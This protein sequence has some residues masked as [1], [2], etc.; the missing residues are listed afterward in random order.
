MPTRRLPS[1]R[2]STQPTSAEP[3]AWLDSAIVVVRGQR[4]I[5]S[6]DL[7]AVYG[8]APKAFNQAIRRN[9]ERFPPDFA[10]RLTLDEAR[11]AVRSRSQSV[12]LNEQP[13]AA[14]KILRSQSV[15]L[16]A[17][18]PRRAEISRSQS[19][20]LSWGA[21]IKYAPLAFTEHG[22]VMAAS[23]LNSPKAVEMSVFV[24]RAF[25]RLRSLVAGQKE[26]AAQLTLLE[27]RVSGHDQGLKAIIS[28]LRRLQEPPPDP[29][30]PA[31]WG[32]LKVG[33]GI[34]CRVALRAL[35]G[36]S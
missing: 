28:A 17:A 32:L 35:V 34:S 9:A 3:T 21:N 33:D 27:R 18:S 26:L 15:T 11:E 5:L 24:V 20:T 19:V 13:S 10:F 2:K 8:V 36:V 7:A 16:D 22:A 1:T 6:G 25:L 14:H 31:G 4:V 29:P 23:V 12:I 30:R